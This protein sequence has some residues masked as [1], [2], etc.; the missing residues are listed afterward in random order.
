MDRF[1]IDAERKGRIALVVLML[2]LACVGSFVFL[3]KAVLDAHDVT[4]KETRLQEAADLALRRVEQVIRQG[5]ELTQSLHQQRLTNCE[6]T[7]LHS[8][9]LHSIRQSAVKDVRVLGPSGEVRCSAFEATLVF[10]L[11]TAAAETY[12]D[13]PGSGL[14]LFALDQIIGTSVGVMTRTGAD[15]GLATILGLGTKEVDLMPRELSGF[16][17]LKVEIDDNATLISVGPMLDDARIATARSASLPVHVEIAL[18]ANAFDRWQLQDNSHSLAIAGFIGFLA[19]LLLA[20]LVIRPE[21]PVTALDRAIARKAFKPWLQPVI[22]ITSGNVTGAEILCRQI[23]PDGQIIPPSRFIELAEQSG[24]IRAITWQVLE[25]AI[26]E[27][28]EILALHPWFRLAVNIAPNHFLEPGFAAELTRRVAGLDVNP[29][30]IVIELTEREAFAD[31]DVAAAAVREVHARGF[32][33]AIDDVGIGHSG[34]SQI[35]AL[36]ADV[37]KIDK[38]F[39]DAI[40]RDMGSR[41]IIQ[42]LVRMAQEMNIGLVAEGVETDEQ[43]A[44]LAAC[45]VCRAQGYLFAKPMAPELFA[46]YAVGK[47]KTPYTPGRETT[48]RVR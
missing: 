10:D 6:E 36:G 48:R 40:G 35:H 2:M 42:M 5:T 34:L 16:Y 15:A 39:V 23:G 33:V 44:A 4:M 8:M 20:R 47:L 12:T 22:D 29:E 28:R 43:R 9:R 21:N 32:K 24:R 14:S 19:A 27:T 46:D 1:K 25:A 11:K 41:V 26:E 30:Q 3:T 38:F 18:D 17:R 45:G 7:T 13:I 31:L 37:I